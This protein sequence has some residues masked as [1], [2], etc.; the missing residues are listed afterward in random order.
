MAMT[1]TLNPVW[2]C[3]Q[4][5][6]VA[7]AMAAAVLPTH[8]AAQVSYQYTNT[9]DGSLNENTA[10]CNNRLQRNF[11]VSDSFT[12]ADV[13]LGVLA[14]HTY[15][16]DLRIYLRSPAG[17]TIQLTSGSGS[18]G[19]DNYNVRFD[20]SA[21]SPIDDY[22][23]PVSVNSGTSVPPYAAR[24][25]PEAALSAFNGQNSAGTWR[26]EI[27]DQY[28][29]DSGTFYQ[30]DLF[31]TSNNSNYAD[32]GLT[33]S[34]SNSTPSFGQTV[35]YT[36]NATNASGSPQTA[37][38]ITVGYSLPAGLTYVS[39]SGGSYN[40]ATGQWQVGTLTPGT[41]ATLQVTATVNATAGATVDAYAE[42]TASSRADIDSTP[43]N[44]STTEDDDDTRS[45]TVAG[46]R[47]AGIAP[48][49]SCPAGTSI[50]DWDTR[51][52][53]AGTTNNTYA[54]AG[55]GNIQ[56]TMTNPGQWLSNATFGGQSPTRQNGLHAATNQYS[57]VQLVNLAS[58]DDL[59]TTTINLP[60]AMAGAQFTIFDVDYNANQFADRVVVEGRLNGATVLP[61]LTNGVVNYVIGN[62]AYGDGG[63]DND[64][65]NGN[66]VVTF[67]SAIDTIIIR[68]GDHALAPADPG[69]QAIALHDI[70]F[71]N[72]ST[73]LDVT[74]I[75]SI[76]SDPVSG[77]DNAK[78]IPDAVVE[79]CI[80]ISNTGNATA[81]SILASDPLPANV[82]YVANSI[83]SGTSCG[84]ATAVEDD[85]SSGADE[86]D[87]VGASQSGGLIQISSPSL[88]A[89]A[90]IA[91]KFR[92]V[93]N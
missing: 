31:L 14:A 61:T 60:A 54:F 25:R 67:N 23:T 89:G 38:G 18:N 52:W 72:P 26:M 62:S 90:S 43:G 55:L 81:T 22:T 39:H 28:N 50:F 69:Q 2:K 49:L 19:T 79:Y 1:M 11:V 9:T 51:S 30:T 73:T 59:V 46:S 91:V 77:T 87:P 68:Y 7:G 45:I 32:L 15:R 88:A 17:T 16:G 70:T 93:V 82:S 74:K 64:S 41:S 36:L 92:A 5:A 33:M 42:I 6:A 65:P 66:V 76:I 78:A 86:S 75:S 8:A 71:C 20:D 44:G 12:I 13:D 57:V 4:L 56:F 40:P 27:C 3:A 34:V 10:P 85:N 80:L 29:Q 24:Y 37:S 47:V 84:N 21:A 53:A 83:R 63:S 48:T 35:T 58:R